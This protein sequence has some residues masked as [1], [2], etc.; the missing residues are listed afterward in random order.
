MVL[1][2]GRVGHLRELLRLAAAERHERR[3]GADQIHARHIFPPAILRVE[4]DFG[5]ADAAFGFADA[6]GLEHAPE[7]AGDAGVGGGGGGV[8]EEG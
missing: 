5:V 3:D 4:I 1:Q 2:L 8:G 6:F 7:E